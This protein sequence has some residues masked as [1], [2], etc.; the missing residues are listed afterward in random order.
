MS[1]ESK[2]AR[3]YWIL[4]LIRLGGLVMVVAGAMSVAGTLP[5]SEGQGAVLMVAGVVEFFFIPLL[6]SKHWKREAP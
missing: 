6:L 2:A 5:I 4:Q 1:D 3:R